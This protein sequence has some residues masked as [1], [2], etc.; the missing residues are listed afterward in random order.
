MFNRKIKIISY[1]FKIC[2]LFNFVSV[3]TSCK[4]NKSRINEHL[5]N[6]LNYFCSINKDNVST[7]SDL[8]NEI[9]KIIRRSAQ[10]L[11]IA[12]D[13]DSSREIAKRSRQTPRTANYLLKRARDVAQMENT[14]IEKGI[15]Q[16]ALQMIGIDHA[17]LSEADIRMLRTLIEKFNGG[18]VGLNTLAASLA[19]EEAT[20]EEF[21]EPYFLQIG[22]LER[23][24]RGRIA[25]EKAY[26]HLNIKFP[27]NRQKDLL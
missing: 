4:N 13:D 10:I 26:N 6:Y 27:E 15:A 9:E 11:N 7:F 12:I 25:T 3:F 14:S 16:K 19:E 20:I 18:P 1:F 22:F 23:T 24:P 2:C 17:G 5:D 21:H 8:Y